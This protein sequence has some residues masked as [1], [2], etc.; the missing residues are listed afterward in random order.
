MV[1]TITRFHSTDSPSI[2]EL[3]ESPLPNTKR[4]VVAKLAALL[5]LADAM[6]V[7][8]QQKI[9]KIAVS[10]KPTTVQITATS[11]DDIELEKWSFANRADFF[12]EVYGITAELKGKGQYGLGKA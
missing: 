8:R 4:M 5:R 3:Q 7:S 1:G 11:T 12:A 9:S 10:V 6:D 2:E